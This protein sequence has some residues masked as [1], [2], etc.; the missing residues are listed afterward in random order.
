MSFEG[1]PMSLTFCMSRRDSAFSG[2]TTASTPPSEW[3]LRDVGMRSVSSSWAD[4]L[5]LLA[6]EVVELWEACDLTGMP[7]VE[8]P[9]DEMPPDADGGGEVRVGGGAARG[10]ERDSEGLT[11]AGLGA[12]SEPPHA[13]RRRVLAAGISLVVIY[14]FLNPG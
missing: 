12:T 3:G 8:T 13:A 10:A 7:P 14:S 5:E 1:L 4:L 11:L 2:V 9:P 6:A